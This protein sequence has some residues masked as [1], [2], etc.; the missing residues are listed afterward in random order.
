[1]CDLASERLAGRGIHLSQRSGL[2]HIGIFEQASFELERK[3]AADRC[4]QAGFGDAAGADQFRKARI[5][6]ALRQFGIDARMKREH[7]RLIIV[8][9]HIMVGHEIGNAAIVA[10]IGA[11]ELKPLATCALEQFKIGVGRNAL[12]LIIGGH[13]DSGVGFPDHLFEG[14]Q[15]ILP[16]SPFAHVGGRGVEPA[17]RRAVDEMLQRGENFIGGKWP[18]PLLA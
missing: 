12:N 5:G 17:L 10:E 2:V 15:E 16:Q 8:R 1:M 18:R 4:V 11:T 13:D 7:C 14:D 9:S 6:L 3:D